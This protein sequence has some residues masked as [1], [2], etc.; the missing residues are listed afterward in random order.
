MSEVDNIKKRYEKRNDPEISKLYDAENL[1]VKYNTAERQKVYGSIIKAWFPD[2]QKIRL[3]EIGAGTGYNMKFFHSLGI[4]FHSLYANELIDERCD[5]INKEYP[6]FRL[7]RGDA[8]TLKADTKFEIVF[9]STVFTSILL[10][11][12]KKRL[13]GKMWDMLKAGGIILWYDFVYNNPRN[14]DVR[15]VPPGEIRR[16]FPLAAEIRFTKVT[17]APPIGRRVGRLYKV[18]NFMFPFLRTHVI[19]EIRKKN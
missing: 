14:K 10:S 1:F 16:L 9:Q 18:I 17:L 8:L 19:A 2:L 3:L 4:P 15:G 13:A 6:G 11:D 7:L 5:I 12:L